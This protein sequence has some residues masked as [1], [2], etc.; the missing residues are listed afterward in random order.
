MAN[1]IGGWRGV[2]DSSLPG[3][4]FVIAYLVDGSNL[5]PAIWAAVVTGA[6][7]AVL[8]LARKQSLQQVISGF[9][10]IA[11][12]AWLASRTGRAQDFYLPGLLLSGGYAVAFLVSILVGHPLVGYAVGAATGDLTGWRSVPEQRRAYTLATWFFVA[13]YALRIAVLVPLYLA[14]AVA[15]LGIMKVI[16]GYPMLA[17]AAYLSFRVISKARRESPV[18][19]RPGEPDDETAAEAVVPDGT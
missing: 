12:A 5:T 7:I 6:L 19:P 15:A 16:L 14:G 4:V 10:G 17:L 8:R 18:P 3:V 11:F 13:Q 2:I 9:V 1:A